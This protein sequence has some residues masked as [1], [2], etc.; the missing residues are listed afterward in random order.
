MDL[1]SALPTRT[2]CIPNDSRTI[3]GLITGN[4]LIFV[5]YCRIP[6]MLR[7]IARRVTAAGYEMPEKRIS[8]FFVAFIFSCG[9]THLVG[10]LVFFLPWFRVENGIIWVTAI[11]SLAT[12]Q[13]L[14]REVPRIVDGITGA[15]RLSDVLH[16]HDVADAADAAQ[17]HSTNTNASDSLLGDD[18]KS[19]GLY[20]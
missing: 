9:L 7:R 20:E 19:G 2:A 17:A 8:T 11:V 3:L 1:S 18:N 13:I 4:L 10:A 12:S 5:A 15:T 6:M 14:W 16:Q